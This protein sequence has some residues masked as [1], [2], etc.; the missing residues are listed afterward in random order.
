[1]LLLR[2]RTASSFSSDTGVMGGSSSSASRS[3]RNLLDLKL[4]LLYLEEAAELFSVSCLEQISD[5]GFS[6]FLAGTAVPAPSLSVSLSSGD[7]T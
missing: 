5:L 6:A 1:M 7:I 4:E 3:C 2:A